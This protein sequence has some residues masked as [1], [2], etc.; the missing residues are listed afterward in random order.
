MII[1]K[2]LTKNIKLYAKLLKSVGRQGRGLTEKQP[3]SPVECAILIQRLMDE[4]NESKIQISER[5]DLGRPKDGTDIYKKRDT[6]QIDM[7]LSLLRVSEKS[8]DLAGWGWEG[9][10]KIPFTT[11]AIMAGTFTNDEQDKI[12][13]AAL[14]GEKESEIRKQDVTKLRKWKNENNDLSIDEGI[15]KVLKLKPP[16]GTNHLILLLMEDKLKKFCLMHP[17][18]KE[19]IIQSLRKRIKGEFYFVI[20]NDKT[21]TIG[22]DEEAFKTFSFQKSE[23]DISFTEFAN[24]L[25]EEELEL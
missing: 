3:L 10:P 2:K 21:L 19:K 9:L 24:N 11:I 16:K 7:F 17:E 6:T 13:Q 18:H 8:R 5:L 14:R 1:L 25:L 4:E 12:L 22:T 20:T 15:E 23:K